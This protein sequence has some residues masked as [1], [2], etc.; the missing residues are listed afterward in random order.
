MPS[1]AGRN[2]STNLKKNII[3]TY[4]EFD[5]QKPVNKERE[6]VGGELTTANKHLYWEYM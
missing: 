4:I 6:R 5:I 3:Y 1:F 2:N